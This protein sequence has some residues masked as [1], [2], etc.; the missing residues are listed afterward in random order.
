MHAAN[1]HFPRTVTS[2]PIF[3]SLPYTVVCYCAIHSYSSACLACR[4]PL[5]ITA[6]VSGSPP[7]IRYSLPSPVVVF[8]IFELLQLSED[9]V[10]AVAV[11][12]VNLITSQDEL[13]TITGVSWGSRL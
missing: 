13:D 1:P 7:R 9:A 6:I 8:V 11:G 5:I 2:T 12:V 3:I 10:L 4:K